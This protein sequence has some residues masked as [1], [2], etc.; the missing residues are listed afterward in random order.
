MLSTTIVFILWS[1]MEG[2]QRW[3]TLL[4]YTFN[5]SPLVSNV[6]FG[7]ILVV[8][9]KLV[10]LEF[11][12]PCNPAWNRLFSSAFFII[13]AV[14][15]FT[16]MLIIKEC[17]WYQCWC[18]RNT[19]YSFVPAIVWL[20]LLFFDGQCLACAMT[21]WEGR[22]VHMAEAPKRKWCKPKENV[23]WQDQLYNTHYFFFVSQ[24]IGIIFLMITCAGLILYLI[25][26]N[27]Q[28]K[29]TKKEDTEEL[30][31]CSDETLSNV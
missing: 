11:E 8:L 18:S 13:P 9:E 5:N 2:K 17:R 7:F 19:V 28:E 30:V 31:D 10:E 23:T 27:C 3:F 29:Q 15:A 26:E 24:G 16:L 25:G 21:D 1:S 12:C 6:A 14:M 20:I 4:R 22:F